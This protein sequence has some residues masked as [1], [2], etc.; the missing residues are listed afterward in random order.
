MATMTEQEAFELVHK[1]EVEGELIALYM[2]RSD[3]ETQAGRE[4]TDEE[5]NRIVSTRGFCKGLSGEELM[6]NAWL[7]VDSILEE[8]DLT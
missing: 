8:A 6:E 7:I 1:A 2:C 5:W 4:L 3:F